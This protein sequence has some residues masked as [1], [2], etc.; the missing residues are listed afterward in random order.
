[1][2]NI[3]EILCMTKLVLHFKLLKN[4]NIFHVNGY[5]DNFTKFLPFV[6]NVL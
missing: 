3:V 4:T 5:I 6:E 2:I 1:M